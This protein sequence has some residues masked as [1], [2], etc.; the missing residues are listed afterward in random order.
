MTRCSGF[1]GIKFSETLGTQHLGTY[2][3]EKERINSNVEEPSLT[4][5]P[6]RENRDEE[7]VNIIP[8]KVDTFKCE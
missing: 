6:T 2:P 1:I 7:E 3:P 4:L 8:E 5:T